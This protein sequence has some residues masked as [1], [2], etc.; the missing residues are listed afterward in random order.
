MSGISSFDTA[1]LE[2]ER[3]LTTGTD[4]T[5]VAAITPG[6][7]NPYGLC[8]L[9]PPPCGLPQIDAIPSPFASSRP[10]VGRDDRTARIDGWKSNRI[11][12][13]TFRFAGRLDWRVM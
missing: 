7:L 8:A 5:T 4:F 1:S 13:R 6:R 3:D 11:D 12:L 10:D 2:I 9:Q